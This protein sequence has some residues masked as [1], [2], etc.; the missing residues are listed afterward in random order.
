MLVCT[1]V[2]LCRYLLGPFA[3][4]DLMVSLISTFLKGGA[5]RLFAISRLRLVGEPSTQ[6]FIINSI[7]VYLHHG[8]DFITGNAKWFTRWHTRALASSRAV[9]TPSVIAFSAVH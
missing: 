1:N 9:T 3:L 5:F 4:L 2:I 6:R 8:R 7:W